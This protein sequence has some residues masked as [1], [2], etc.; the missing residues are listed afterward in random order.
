MATQKP[1]SQKVN[2]ADLII[3]YLGA[4]NDPINHV[5]TP[6]RPGIRGMVDNLT[7]QVTMFI[8]E[9][10]PRYP[11][12]L[13]HE[14]RHTKAPKTILGEGRLNP[15]QFGVDVG[16]LDPEKEKVIRRKAISEYS[17]QKLPSYRRGSFAEVTAELTAYL[18]LRDL[19]VTLPEEEV[20][21]YEAVLDSDPNF[22]YWMESGL[23]SRYSDTARADQPKTKKG[24]PREISYT[25]PEQRMQRTKDS[26]GMQLLK[27]LG[28]IRE[29]GS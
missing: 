15:S 18:T 24:E 8:P 16:I 17:K 9:T 28:I 20:A 27:Y 25:T 1:E 26:Y 3:T 12:T 11:A 6:P 4:Q 21:K 5:A 10:D 23:G 2:L 14:I 19:G 13:A 29:D 7:G 22:R